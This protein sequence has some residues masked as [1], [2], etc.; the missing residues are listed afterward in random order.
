MLV[1][2][3]GIV[4]HQI[5][6]TDSSIIAHI[7]TELGGRQSFIIQG[8]RSK[9]SGS[10]INLLQPL[11]ILEMEVYSRAGRE[12]QKVKE[13]RSKVTL[14]DIPFNPFKTSIALFLAELLYKVLRE[15]E[16]NPNLFRFLENSIEML[17]I[18]EKGVVNF[19]LLFMLQLTKHLGFY[20]ENNFNEKKRIFDLQ[21]GY[22]I[23]IPPLHPYILSSEHSIK[24][25]EILAANIQNLELIQID[26][27]LRSQLLDKILLYYSLH[28]GG[29][30]KFHSL[31]VL[32]E[33]FHS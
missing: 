19:H 27:A 18:I 23:E 3:S 6:Y 29:M 20:P 21:N 9:S 1:K 33:V 25:N 30:D 12:L 8:I 2:T 14:T 7:Y 16:A 24:L 5:K 4:L 10:K 28:I 13:I 22:F 31:E 17:D 26:N 32:R 11:Y 15:N